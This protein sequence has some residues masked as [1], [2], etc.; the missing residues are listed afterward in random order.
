LEIINE[1]ILEAEGYLTK[2][3][4][5]RVLATELKVEIE[6]QK[7]QDEI[8]IKD[9]ISGLNNLII[10]GKIISVYPIREFVKSDGEKGK[11]RNIVITDGK[12]NLKVNLWNDSAESLNDE[13]I[14][15]N[16][17]FTSAYTRQGINGKIEL[18]INNNSQIKILNNNS[19]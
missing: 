18:N 10:R 15:K 16:I 14:G 17:K 12:N 2:E 7:F 13:S 3:S 6:K 19:I 9:I 11:L 5:A 8:S 4:A 1:K